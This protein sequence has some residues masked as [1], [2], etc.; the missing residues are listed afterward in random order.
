MYRYPNIKTITYCFCYVEIL[1]TYIWYVYNATYIYVSKHLLMITKA[2]SLLFDS[3]YEYSSLLKWK[4]D[5]SHTWSMTY[6]GVSTQKL[7]TCSRKISLWSGSVAHRVFHWNA[8]YYE[9]DMLTAPVLR[10]VFA[11]CLELVRSF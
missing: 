10:I 5:K 7:A 9:R 11:G 1:R 8:L 3:W 6:F 2:S 4:A